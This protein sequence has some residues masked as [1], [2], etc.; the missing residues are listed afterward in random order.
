MVALLEEYGAW[1]RRKVD[2]G[3]AAGLL[4]LCGMGYVVGALVE[5]ETALAEEPML[6]AERRRLII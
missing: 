4:L 2:F 5:V 6:A 1:P 3:V